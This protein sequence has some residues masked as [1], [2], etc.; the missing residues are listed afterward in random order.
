MTRELRNIQLCF[1]AQRSVAPGGMCSREHV[2]AGPHGS[3]WIRDRLSIG[4]SFLSTKASANSCGRMSS[5][6]MRVAYESDI[7]PPPLIISI[8]NAALR[9]ATTSAPAVLSG[10]R[11]GCEDLPDTI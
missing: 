10:R 8:T 1:R 11:P 6:L 4:A 5:S 2:F 7:G 9:S 3:G